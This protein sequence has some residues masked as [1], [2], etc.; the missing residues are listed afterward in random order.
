MEDVKIVSTFNFRLKSINYKF[1]FNW[2]NF[3]NFCKG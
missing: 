2:K 3:T 1:R